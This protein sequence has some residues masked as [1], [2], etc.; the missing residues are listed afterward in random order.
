M[1][2]KGILYVL[3]DRGF[4]AAFDAKT[5][6]TVYDR[7]RIAPSAKAFTASPWAYGDRIFCLDEDGRTYVVQAGAEFKL[8]RVNELDE[9]CMASPAMAHGSLLIRTR[10][11]LV[12]IDSCGE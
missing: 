10:G 1:L 7:Q 8:L 4:L 6:A 12:R 3:Y 11:H 2:Y 5:G 9:M